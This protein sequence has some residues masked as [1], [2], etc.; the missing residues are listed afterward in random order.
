[1]VLTLSL[2]LAGFFVQLLL[3]A[4]NSV[5]SSSNG[6]PTGFAG[7]VKWLHLQG[8]NSLARLFL[9]VMLFPFFV[10]ATAKLVASSGVTLET[11]ALSG[12]AGYS[13]SALLN[14]LTGLIPALR[15]EIP[16]VAP[17]PTDPHLSDP[18]RDPPVWTN[19]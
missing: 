5:Q 11:W 14:Q 10:Q 15:V 3:Q 7:I 8:I 16:N 1:M 9:S 4:Q 13:A 2:Y 12:I 6:L 17:P 19:K 18:L